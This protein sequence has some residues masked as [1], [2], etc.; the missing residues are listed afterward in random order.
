M[1]SP[2]KDLAAN[3]S[4]PVSSP[5]TTGGWTPTVW[6][7]HADVVELVLGAADA[8]HDEIILMQPAAADGRGRGW[9]TADRQIAPGT[10]YRFRVDGDLAPDPRSAWQPAGVH[11]A[12]VVVDHSTHPWADAGW[13]AQPLSSAVLYELHVGT[14][15]TEGTYQ[16]A[17]AR[18]DHLVDLG[19]THVELLPLAT[20][21]GH[22]GWGY[23]GVH[24][25]APHPAYGTP[26]DLKDLVEACHVR[27]LAVILDVVY[28]HLGPV[29]NHLARFGPYFTDH[30]STP[31]GS[32]VNLDGPHSDGVRQF[33]VENALMWLRDYHFDGLRL[34][35]VH[36]LLDTSAIHILE[37]LADEVARLSRALGRPLV[38]IAENDTN[39]PRLV[40][41][42][43]LGGF[44]LDAHWCDDVHH[45]IHTVVTGETDGYYA[46][47]LAA[48]GFDVLERALRQ[49]YVYDGR[50]SPARSRAVG[51][52]PIE[53]A[54]R[55]LVACIQN[56]DQVGNRARGERLHQ[57][58]SFAEQKIAAA[59][60]LTAPFVPLLFQGEEWAASAPFPFFADHSDPELVEAVRIG[61][62]NEFAAFGW[63]PEDVLD[64]ES[65]ETF[66]LAQLDWAEHE[67]AE[68]QDML[69][70]YR[71]LI[72]LRRATPALLDDRLG[73]TVVRADGDQ[74]TIVVER[75]DIVV[76][77]NLSE[78][79]RRFEVE[80]TEVLASGPCAVAGS[81]R[82]LPPLSVAIVQR[83]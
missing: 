34:D 53:L 80:G 26:D 16:G 71:A 68:H 63:R 82:V 61:R 5:G 7:P 31:W 9:W 73:H 45:A 50:W 21:D 83:G 72:E 81:G 56:H 49:G 67:I 58:T 64:P 38:V 33:I 39:D 32:A 25:Y 57:L 46:D 69:R 62:R 66:A 3:A 11:G 78:G 23:D 1:S 74:R 30:Y 42:P 35:A 59:L 75:G 18:L 77:A 60:L 13:Q 48:E 54:G 52:P 14:F 51:R 76:L 79:E 6:A 65:P 41:P 24:L 55:N 10:A 2:T 15:T 12:S 17:Q 44:G 20:F 8:P 36:A 27:G 28:N 43:A 22:H 70:W 40:R 29:G 4:E 19:V 47:Y 37:Q